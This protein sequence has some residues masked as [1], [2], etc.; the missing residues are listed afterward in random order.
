MSETNSVNEIKKL[1]TNLSLKDAAERSKE[2]TSQKLSEVV[3]ELLSIFD[4]I[5]SSL[6]SIETNMISKNDIGD[7]LGID[8]EGKV[9]IIGGIG[10]GLTDEDLNDIQYGNY[11]GTG[12][13][14]SGDSRLT[15]ADIDNILMGNYTEEDVSRD[16]GLT[17]DEIDS[18]LAS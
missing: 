17:A 14:D 3:S 5:N 6:S 9:Y 15:A 10:S 8:E 18:I 2:Y 13:D 16:S 4:D 1:I 7:G 12:K 11:D